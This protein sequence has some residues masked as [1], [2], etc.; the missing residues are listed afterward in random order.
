[1]SDPLRNHIDTNWMT[2]FGSRDIKKRFLDHSGKDH[3]QWFWLRHCYKGRWNQD[4][5]SLF[6]SQAH[7][8]WNMG[9]SRHQI[10]GLVISRGP[11]KGDSQAT[12]NLPKSNFWNLGKPS[13][14]LF[15]YFYLETPTFLER[16]F[17]IWDAS[18]RFWGSPNPKTDLCHLMP[19]LVF[20]GVPGKL[21]HKG[22]LQL[23]SKPRKSCESIT[24]DKCF[25]RDFQGKYYYVC[26]A[27]STLCCSSQNEFL[28][29]FWGSETWAPFWNVDKVLSIK[30]HLLL[31]VPEQNP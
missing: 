2:L 15:C 26:L 8:W 30:Y 22:D 23:S 9:Q 31:M 10:E 19:D 27:L 17:S 12:M 1:M 24:L 14:T 11:A 13:N 18:N 16:T 20:N 29:P 4:V 7:A 21:T 3:T 6:T 25:S 5:D 28:S